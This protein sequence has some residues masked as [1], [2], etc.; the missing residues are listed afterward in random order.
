MHSQQKPFRA[1]GLRLASTLAISTMFMLVKLAGQHGIK[2]PEMMFWR[3]AVPLVMLFGWLASTGGL[4]RLRTNR[5]PI[6]FR[7]AFT[8]MVGM[9][10]NFG[11][12]MLLPLAVSTIFGFTTPLFAVILTATVMAG[13]VGKWRWLAVVLGFAGVLLIARPSA[14]PVSPLGAFAGLGAALSVAVVSHQLR[15]LGRTEATIATVFYF[16]LFGVLIMLPAL[17][18]VLTSHSPLQWAMLVAIGTTGLA[19]Q[20]LMTGALRY[21]AVASVIVM[22]YASLIWTTLFGW[23]IFG[24]MPPATTWMGAPLIIAAGLLIAWREHRLAL[25]RTRATGDGNAAPDGS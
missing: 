15:D 20:M 23:H 4:H 19:G 14:M 17:P 21:G 11:S 6:H 13:S 12:V 10:F 18:F 9:A 1:L 16:T 3:Q 22:D 25:G 7:R 24:Q 2:L 5:L 8:G